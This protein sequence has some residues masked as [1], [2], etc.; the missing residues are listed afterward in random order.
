MG[1]VDLAAPVSHIWFFKGV[2]SRIGYLLDMAPKE[3]RRSSTSRLRSS[4]GSTT[5]R[6]RR[7]SASS[8]RRSTRRSSPTRPSARRVM[9]L[10][11]GRGASRQ[12]PRDRRPEGLLRRRPALGGHA[13]R[14]PQEA[15]GR[16]AREDGEGPAQAVRR[17][18]RRHRGLLRGRHRAPAPDMGALPD[19]GAE[20]GDRGRD[21]LPRAEGPLR[22]AV[23]LERVLPRRH[24]R[25]VGA[26]PAPA[27]RPRRRARGARGPGQDG[28][29][30]EAVARG[31]APEGRLGLH[32]RT[33]A[34]GHDPRGRAGDPAGACARWCRCSTAAASRPPT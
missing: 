6:A 18:H 31:E 22:V 8:R 11:G 33:T 10:R 27:G 7:T 29:G 24:G 1:H 21:A 25:R 9:E 3:P 20:A 23:R 14:E 32:P 26:R 17:G 34:R 30:P 4:P 15:V 12:V 13:R 2:P 5:R 16:R 28:Q 19:D